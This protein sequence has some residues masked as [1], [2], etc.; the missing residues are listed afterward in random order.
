MDQ[1]NTWTGAYSDALTK[2]GGDLSAVAAGGYGP[3]PTLLAQ[4]TRQARDGELLAE[5]G[6]YRTDY[7][8][9]LMFLADGGDLAAEAQAQH[10]TGTQWGM[11]NEAGNYPGQVWLAPYTFWYQI[12]P[13]KTS[14]NG[15]A[16][17]WGTMGVVG[18]VFLLLPLIPGLWSVPR[19]IP[20]Y[21]LI[22]RDHYRAQPTAQN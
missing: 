22:W 15:D 18:L 13:F 11:M 3:V 12:P 16:L 1:Q 14:G 9:P 4:L 17:V 10:L 21:R 5:G 6:A 8:L 19:L 7:T 20:V 2:A